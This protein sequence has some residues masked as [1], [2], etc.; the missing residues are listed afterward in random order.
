MWKPSAL[1]GLYKSNAV[2]LLNNGYTVYFKTIFVKH[3]GCK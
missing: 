2:F 1:K 3:L